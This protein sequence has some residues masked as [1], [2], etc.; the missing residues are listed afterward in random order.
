[1]NDKNKRRETENP[2]TW[3]ERVYKKFETY[4]KDKEKT[5]R[6]LAET[7][8]NKADLADERTQLELNKKSVE[9]E[10]FI[11]TDIPKTIEREIQ[12]YRQSLTAQKTKSIAQHKQI[13]HDKNIVENETFSDAVITQMIEQEVQEHRS[14]LISQ[15][16]QQY[17][18]DINDIRTKLNTAQNKCDNLANQIT[19]A[20]SD[21]H[22]AEKMLT[23]ATN[24]DIADTPS[25]FDERN[26][27]INIFSTLFS[28]ATQTHVNDCFS[29]FDEIYS[30]NGLRKIK[31]NALELSAKDVL[32][33]AQSLL[34]RR[35]EKKQKI[36]GLQKEHAVTAADKVLNVLMYKIVPLGQ[37]LLFPKFLERK[38]IAVKILW[39]VAIILATAWV[40]GRSA[41]FILGGIG[42]IIAI[43]LLIIFGVFVAN[44]IA[45]LR[46]QIYIKEMTVAYLF[47]NDT[48]ETLKNLAIYCVNKKMA[49]SGESMEEFI[50]RTLSEAANSKEQ[51][52]LLLV[53]LQQQ[54]QQS[55]AELAEIHKTAKNI[56]FAHADNMELLQYDSL[57]DYRTQ[58]QEKYDS[59]RKNMETNWQ[60]RQNLRITALQQE[61]DEISA[62][63]IEYDTKIA[64]YELEAT[65]KREK[66]QTNWQNEQNQRISALQQQIDEKSSKINDCDTK[67]TA[68]ETEIADLSQKIANQKADCDTVIQE[69]AE[70]YLTFKPADY[71]LDNHYSFAVRKQNDNQPQKWVAIKHDMQPIIFLYDALETVGGNEEDFKSGMKKFLK[72]FTEWILLVNGTKLAKMYYVD[73][74]YSGSFLLD[75]ALTKVG[76]LDIFS[77]KSEV[78]KLLENWREDLPK[79][80]GGITTENKSRYAKESEPVQYKILIMYEA[81]DLF[82]D[83]EFIQLDNIAKDLGVLPVIFLK[84]QDITALDKLKSISNKDLV[85]IYSKIAA[86]KNCY[87]VNLNLDISEPNYITPHDLSETVTHLQQ[88][89]WGEE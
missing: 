84:K 5:K 36:K 47:A 68:H 80:G 32:D 1:M 23:D 34:G 48:E 70:L 15:A 19:A 64:E 24:F 81:A 3:Y 46:L 38:N 66:A 10:R 82:K 22:N 58:M 37:K 86:A 72:T 73:F 85:G 18:T 44:V 27:L 67:I 59:E 53:D 31:E 6:K 54:A 49:E 17:T 14:S 33:T 76:L 61:I 25:F 11:D 51:T 65:S 43:I 52:T 88:M 87:F 9:N 56:D 13:E 30:G 75:N 40:V 78:V 29:S 79:L 20:E 21:L 74:R 4:T 28:N 7:Q 45:K 55:Q 63:I 69:G 83:K 77:K 89:T 2:R 42:L 16:E 41:V 39:F 71:I 60:N 12:E 8:K 50:Q 35:L 26:E 57:N 62:E